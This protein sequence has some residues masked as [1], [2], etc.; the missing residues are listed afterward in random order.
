VAEPNNSKLIR[1]ISETKYI[2]KNVGL[3]LVFY[4]ISGSNQSQ[5]T[6]NSNWFGVKGFLSRS[7][8]SSREVLSTLSVILDMQ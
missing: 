5:L 2:L 1:I 8:Q 3:D 4:V 7:G 6:K